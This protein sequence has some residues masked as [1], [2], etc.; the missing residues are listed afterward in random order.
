MAEV[1]EAE[2]AQVIQVLAEPWSYSR[3]NLFEQCPRKWYQQYVLK[4]R[5]PDSEATALGRA[6]HTAME[7][8]VTQGRISDGLMLELPVRYLVRDALDEL[9]M[10]SG[11]ELAPEDRRDAEDMAI[12]GVRRLSDLEG[13][14]EVETEL[15]REEGGR[16]FRG[17]IDVLGVCRGGPLILDYKTGRRTFGVQDS[18][19]L[20]FYA[21]LYQESR[22]VLLRLHFLRY[23]L[24]KEALVAVEAAEEAGH[25]AMAL[26][27]EI[28][29]RLDFGAAL[30][31]PGALFEPG[32]SKLCAYCHV[33]DECPAVKRKVPDGA[34]T[35][36]EEAKIVGEAALAQ[37]GA[38]KSMKDRLKAFVMKH[39][40]VP[41]GAGQWDNW[42][43]QSME[44]PAGVVMRL[45]TE[46]GLNP[47]DFANMDSRKIAKLPAKT[48]QEVEAAA[49]AKA[50][51]RFE[52]REAG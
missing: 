51:R 21:W 7:R 46:A 25:R 20:P 29:A 2:D 35:S 28:E 27:N 32:P 49:K 44:Y 33:V 47:A 37:E 6:V 18:W 12:A 23:D 9:E 10:E 34:I 42:Q 52:W 1:A 17:Y 11:I 43:N 19:Q 22:E 14:V 40:P 16:R 30:G 4:R 36:L 50:G 3:L 5:S 26:V 45:L 13:S 15:V 31:D 39:G 48:R 24:I 8:Y 38:L 41:V